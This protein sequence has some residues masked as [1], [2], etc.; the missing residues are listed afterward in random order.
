MTYRIDFFAYLILFSLM[1]LQAL[2]LFWAT[3]MIARLSTK[4]GRLLAG[5]IFLAT[6]DIAA[7]LAGLG[8]LPSLGFLRGPV[9]VIAASLIAVLLVFRPGNLFGGLKIAGYFYLLAFLAAGTGLA[10][11]SLTGSAWAG[12]VSAILA[13]LIAGEVGWGIVQRWVWQKTLLLPVEIFLGTERICATALLDTGNSLKDPLTGTPVIIAAGELFAAAQDPHIRAL[14]KA[15]ISGEIG[16]ISELLADSPWAAKI[17]LIPYASLGTAN[18]LL[19][20]VRP[21]RIVVQYGGEQLVVSEAIVGIHER[22][23]SDD[24]SY[25]AL[26]HPEIVQRIGVK[27]T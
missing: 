21:D 11:Q 26:I 8:V 23:L 25:S 17:R 5:A 6:Y 13:I 20:G 14:G 22:S 12:P 3:K 27:T 15:A 10:V 16:K 24:G 18:G 7:D 1:A 4:D 2:V 9:A 19:L